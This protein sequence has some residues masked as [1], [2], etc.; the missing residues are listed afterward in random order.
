[1]DIEDE[2]CSTP[3]MNQEP[4]SVPA[5]VLLPL[6]ANKRKVAWHAVGNAGAVLTIP[7]TSVSLTISDVSWDKEDRVENMW[8]CEAIKKK[9]RPTLDVNQAIISP[10]VIIGP[11]H[12]SHHLQKPVVVSIPH[13][14]HSGMMSS[15]RILQC[16]RLNSGQWKCVAVSGQDNNTSST[17]VYVDYLRCIFVPEKFG[18]Y[19][20]VA[21]TGDIGQ[22]QSSQ[23][24]IKAPVH[25]A[26]VSQER[27]ALQGGES[28]QERN[29][30]LVAEISQERPGVLAGECPQ[31]ITND[32][33]DKILVKTNFVN[34]FIKSCFY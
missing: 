32:A 26:D 14:G 10:I 7:G 28:S 27:V 29:G 34:C 15:I 23:E 18:A 16:D 19:V 1:M 6:C 3:E 30:N 22:I 11:Q 4:D 21:N 5:H 9:L 20:V 17:S 24:R 33:G 2:F 13:T 12:I 8:V 25:R 31:E